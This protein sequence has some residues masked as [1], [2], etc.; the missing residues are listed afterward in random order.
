MP[1]TAT[2]VTEKTPAGEPLFYVRAL[3]P[4]RLET[5]RQ[6][7]CDD[8]GNQGLRRLTAE[9]GEP[10]RCCLRRAEANEELVLIAYCPFGAPGPYAETGPVFIHAE[11]C[12]GYGRP[13]CYPEDFRHWQQVFRCYDS[14]G[15]IVG[16]RLTQA[17]DSPEEVISELFADPTVE[18]IHTR[19]VVYGCYMLEIGR[20]PSSDIRSSKVE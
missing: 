15:D 18:R 19:N 4:E 9:G 3:P 13:E 20:G 6:T 8:G 7:C 12:A 10:L 16:G 17:G 11:K 5:I 14:G 1:T 2:A